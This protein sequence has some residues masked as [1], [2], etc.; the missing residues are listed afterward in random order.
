[1]TRNLFALAL[2][3]SC[4]LASA[5]TIRFKADH[6]SSRSS[7][8]LKFET[9][10]YAGTLASSNKELVLKIKNKGDANWSSSQINLVDISNR[11]AKLCAGKEIVLMPGKKGSVTYTPCNSNGGLFRLEPSYPSKTEFKEDAFFLRGK[12]WK[13][14]IGGETFSFFT[15]I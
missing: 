12:E 9:A 2:I 7:S 4:A 13:L 3:L 15:D 14:T 11:G 8:S 10:S 1:M 5:Q 6:T